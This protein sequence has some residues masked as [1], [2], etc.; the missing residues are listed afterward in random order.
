MPKKSGN[1][2]SP[3]TER[4]EVVSSGQVVSAV[5]MKQLP[6]SA[7]AGAELKRPRAATAARML[8]FVIMFISLLNKKTAAKG[9]GAHSP[10]CD[11]LAQEELVFI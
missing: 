6:S 8:I 7:F 5:G 3:K 1:G 2:S 9:S 11:L 4:S 10:L